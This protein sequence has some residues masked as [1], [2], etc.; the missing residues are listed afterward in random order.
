[1]GQV[2]NTPRSQALM[3][4]RFNED[5]PSQWQKKPNEVQFAVATLVQTITT[6]INGDLKTTT[7]AHP[8]DY[9]LK[10]QSS[11]YCYVLTPDKFEK[12]YEVVSSDN[13]AGTARVKPQPR[14]ALE[15]QGEST[16]FIAPWLDETGSPAEMQL[17]TGDYL[18]SPDGNEVYR[19]ERTEFLE[20]Y[21]PLKV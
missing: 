8:G 16:T 6:S 12:N 3:L 4:S 21:E 18:V 5:F 11:E 20:T 1:M 7:V 19:V 2:I 14:W 15:Y 9:V 13:G 10:G 17:N